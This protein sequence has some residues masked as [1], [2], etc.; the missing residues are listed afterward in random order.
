MSSEGFRRSR[1]RFGA[2]ALLAAA[3]MLFSSPAFAAARANAAESTGSTVT[4]VALAYG[5]TGWSYRQV[6]HDKVPNFYKVGFNDSAW[7]T[8]QEGFG[9]TGGPCSWNK[10]ADV[11]TP[12]T[13]NTDMLVRQSFSLPGD[14][15]DLRVQGTIDNDADVYLNGH[16]LQS[17]QSGDCQ[18]GA[19]ST[20]A[21]QDY[22]KP[23]DVIAVRGQDFGDADYLNVKVTYHVPAAAPGS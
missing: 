1:A 20:K 3:P 21:R 18:A 23:G 19:I 15:T 22:L 8:G 13:L 5:S 9:T 11:H 14:A 17:V 7:P 12:W 2:A 4:V 16:L 6:A 10:P